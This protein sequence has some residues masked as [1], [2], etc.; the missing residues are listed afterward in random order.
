MKLASRAAA[1]RIAVL[2]GIVAFVLVLAWWTMIRMPGRSHGGP[3][4][5][6]TEAEASAAERMRADVAKLAGE[7]GERNV[8]FPNALAQAADHVESALSNAVVREEYRIG[9]GTF[10]NLVAERR[11]NDEIVVV[12]AHY[13]SA[14]GSP[15]AN[16]NASGVAALL[17][18]ARRFATRSPKRTIRFV[19]FTN[20]EA[21]FQSRRWAA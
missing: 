4:P 19:A 20:E 7:L 8:L 5:P 16:D 18:L 9:G 13:D 2:L 11:G 1:R 3:L 14:L 12:G 21:Y 10:A 6:L 15:G 17:E